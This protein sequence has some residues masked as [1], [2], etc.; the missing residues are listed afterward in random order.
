VVV[1]KYRVQKKQT[2]NI[3]WDELEFTIYGHTLYKDVIIK[4][5]Y[6]IRIIDDV[7]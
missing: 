3:E 6:L 1:L 2:L 4:I 7:E 5:E